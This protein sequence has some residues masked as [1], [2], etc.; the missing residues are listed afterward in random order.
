MPRTPDM[1]QSLFA[2]ARFG[3]L[4]VPNRVMMAPLTR[5]R[6]HPDGTPW[7]VAA[8][9]Y[10]QRASAGLIISEATQVA[11]TGKGYLNT[12]GIHSDDQVAAWRG[13]TDAVHAAGGRIFLQLWHVGR[14]SHVSLQPNGQAPVAPSA[15]RAASQTF[16]ANGFEDVSEPRALTTA[17]VPQVIAQFRDGAERAQAAGFDGVEVHGANG[18]LIDQFLRPRTN[19]RD[20]EYG[21]S[22]EN[23]MRFLKEATEAAVAVFGAGRVGVRL[24]PTGQFNDVGEDVATVEATFAPAY[25]MLSGMGL[26]YLHVVEKLPGIDV[27]D[28]EQQLLDRL[29]G[30]YDGAY[31]ANGNF[32]ASQAAAWIDRGRA[33][34]I[35]FGRP[36][37]AN[38]DLPMRFLKGADLTRRT[39]PPSM[40]GM[41]AVTRTIHR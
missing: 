33:V 25:E 5:N 23:R 32:D 16:T 22:V 27:A 7:A 8:T 36:F 38:P 24:S 12:P 31:I 20:D 40:E 6:A 13:I 1:T 41:S 18:Y 3:D 2:P 21:G 15:I 37:I 17:E 19:Q 9:Y 4:T 11:A 10:A 34:A 14:I 28:D 30:L 26:A 29:H 39:R 35:T